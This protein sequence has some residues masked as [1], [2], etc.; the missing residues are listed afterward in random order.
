VFVAA[1]HAQ[2]R[3]SLASAHAFANA[4]LPA[5]PLSFNRFFVIHGFY[6]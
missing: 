2:P 6:L 5:L 3:P 1:K 4:K